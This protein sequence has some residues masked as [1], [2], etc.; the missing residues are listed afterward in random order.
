MLSV[1]VCASQGLLLK[2]DPAAAA[3]NQSNSGVPFFALISC[4]NITAG[5]DTTDDATAAAVNSITALADA[6]QLAAARD[7]SLAILYSENEAV[8]TASVG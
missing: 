8:S 1:T 7:A 5:L 2:F 3:A 4:D 6:F